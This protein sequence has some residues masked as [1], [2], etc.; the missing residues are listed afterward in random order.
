MWDKSDRDEM[1]AWREKMKREQRNLGVALCVFA[2]VA[3]ACFGYI[4][5]KI[6]GVL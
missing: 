5:L 6:G 1:N 3:T 2:A 4:A